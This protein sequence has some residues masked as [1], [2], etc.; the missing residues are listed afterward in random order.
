MKDRYDSVEFGTLKYMATSGGISCPDSD[1]RIDYYNLGGYPTAWFNG[2]ETLR[3]AGSETATGSTYDPVVQAMLDD[4]TPVM[5]TITGFSVTFPAYVTVEVELTD[6]ID[7]ITG[8]F[9]RGF[10]LENDLFYG[11]TT[12]QDILCDLEETPLTISLAGETQTVTI[13]FGYA[14]TGGRTPSNYANCWIAAF[15]QRDSDHYI[16]QS[17]NSYPTPDYAFRYFALGS[18]VDVQDPGIF[19]FGEIQ[20]HNTGAL[21]DTYT[22]SLDLADLPIGWDGW[23]SDGIDDFT[24]L[25]VTL[26]PGEFASYNVYIDAA[27]TGSG[28]VS[29]DIHSQNARTDDR[30]LGYTV[31]TSDVNILLVDDDGSEAYE[32]L[33][34]EPALATTGRTFATWDR[35]AAGL[36]GELL[37]NF[38]AVVWSCGW[39]FPTVTEEDRDAI[40]EYLDGGGA[41]FITGQDIGWELNGEGPAAI[42]WYH[43][44]LGATYIADD[45]NLYN[46]DGVDGDPVSDGLTISIIGGDGANNQDY[47]SDIDPYDADSHTVFTYNTFRNGA[48]RKETEAFRSVY[49]AFGYEAINN[50]PDRATVMQRIVD[51]IIPDLTGGPEDL[52]Q[53]PMALRQNAPNPFNPIT[54]IS[55]RLGSETDIRLEIFDTRGRL[56]RVLDEGMRSAGEHSVVWNGRDG[57]GR[58]LSSGVYFYR[59]L[60]NEERQTRKMLMLK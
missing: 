23:F 27:D 57:E 11:G 10:V 40:A 26:A 37:A 42:Q 54:K 20:L 22:L 6:D 32:T 48:V 39:A 29:F 21:T 4:A 47:P 41:L 2:T 17:T 46:L 1:D 51:W 35:N 50:A 12:Y 36:T 55:Y 53:L 19:G 58:E 25:E 49:F 44:Y 3:G 18:R 52:P 34:F 60:G 15:V 7:D 8:H 45:T 24:Y 13:P 9:I 28:T 16:Y 30:Q 31:I 38:E 33:Y 14:A 59:L 5:V 56:V 43:D